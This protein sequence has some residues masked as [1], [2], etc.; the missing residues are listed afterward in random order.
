MS[1]RYHYKKGAMAL[2]PY[3]LEKMRSLARQGQLGRSH[4]ISSDGGLS[5]ES[6]TA[7]PEIFAAGEDAAARPDT[8]RPNPERSPSAEPTNSPTWQYRTSDGVQ[9]GPVPESQIHD[10]IRLGRLQP[11]DTVWTAAFGDKWVAAADVPGLAGYF[12]PEPEDEPDRTRDRRRRSERQRREQRG[13]PR[14][15][16][17]AA[18]PGKKPFNGTG[19]SGFV[20][21]VVAI[22]LLAM[23]CLVWVVVAESFFWMFNIVIPFTVLSIV[24]LVLSVIGL[25]KQPRG[26]ATTGTVLGVIALMLGI[27]AIVGWFMLPYRL[28]MQRRTQIDSFATDIKLEQKNLADELAGYRRLTREPDEDEEAFAARGL[29]GRRRVAESLDALV[30]SYQNHVTATART[31]EFKTAF[32]DLATLRK[33]LEDV[34]QAAQAVEGLEPIDVLEAGNA[35]VQGLKVL[36]DTLRLYERGEISLQQA[37]AK[38]TGR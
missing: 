29:L 4:Q 11:R 2:G 15:E 38:M 19:L 1:S 12:V 9:Q 17:E 27:M 22:V 13:R 6:G 16:A 21:S 5:W 26:M 20:C 30:T 10:L 25:S 23:P 31:A 32:E 3:P 24:G 33:T 8:S 37:E 35:N 36:M 7:Y 28:A 34:G 14:G 18:K